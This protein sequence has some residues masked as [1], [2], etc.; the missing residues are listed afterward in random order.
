MLSC[1]FDVLLPMI[2]LLALCY[3]YDP[4]VNSFIYQCILPQMRV[5]IATIIS[6]SV[7]LTDNVNNSSYFQNLSKL[8][9]PLMMMAMAS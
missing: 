9:S 3:N 1:L 7:F 2:L 4:L 5:V 6:S 8:A